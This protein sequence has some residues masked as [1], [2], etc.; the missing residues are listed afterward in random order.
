M[1]CYAGVEDEGMELEPRAG[2]RKLRNNA[3]DNVPVI[4]AGIRIQGMGEAKYRRRARAHYN[5]I[6]IANA[7]KWAA[8]RPSAD[9][10][11]FT[12]ADLIVDW[13]KEEGLGIRGHTL[14]WGN[15]LPDWMNQSLGRQGVEDAA[16][17]H[18]DAVVSRYRG[19]IEHWDVINEAVDAGGNLR[20]DL[21]FWSMGPGYI[22]EAFRRAHQADPDAKLAYND[23]GIEFPGPKQDGVYDLVE[24]LLDDGV[25]V[26]EVG[27]Q[28]HTRPGDWA[29][30]AIDVDDLRGAIARFGSLGVDV[31]ITELDVRLDELDGSVADPL[32]LQRDVYQAVGAA[33]YA[34]P[35]CRGVTTWGFTDKHT[36][37]P[38][39]TP[40]VF[41]TNY[42]KK[43]AFHGL[44]AGLAGDPAPSFAV[45]DSACPIPGADFCEPM[46]SATFSELTKVQ[47]AGGSVSLTNNAYRGASALQADLPTAGSTRRAYASKQLSGLGSEIWTRVYLYVPSASASHFTAMAMDEPGAP[48]WGVSMGSRNDG[49]TFL[50]VA[51]S[52]ATS[53]AGVQFPRDRWACFEMRVSVANSGGS[54]EL[55]LDGASVLHINDVDTQFAGDYG[56]IKTGVMYTPANGGAVTV[57]ADELAV[58]Q[59]RLGCD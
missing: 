16:W 27:I 55:F 39:A 11:D 47:V 35:A 18:I 34:E 37:A 14:L 48:Y 46:E 29:S 15:F 1:A 32:Q 36:Y 3:S 21:Y 53:V 12:D 8:L 26:D 28:M 54:T 41:D 4:G 22:A 6:T 49:R 56:T 51:G 59:T 13:A 58:G 43:P 25:P 52:P 20:N 40:L 30:G 2:A 31:Y 24:S 17:E 5:Q 10:F 33:C 38:E 57:R 7:V 45:W 23:F 44:S 50:R 9:V 19:D 42:R